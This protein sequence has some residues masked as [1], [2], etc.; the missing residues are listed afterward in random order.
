M[1]KLLP[2]KPE[3]SPHLSNQNLNKPEKLGIH[4]VAGDAVIKLN[5][6]IFIFAPHAH[7]PSH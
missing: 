6:N 7:R 3:T 2:T 4:L 1:N 5:H